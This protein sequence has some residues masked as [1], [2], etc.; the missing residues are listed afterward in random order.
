MDLPRVTDAYIN[1][2]G[3]Y[4][5]F[6]YLWSR[7]RSGRRESH[8][9]SLFDAF[10]AHLDSSHKVLSKRASQTKGNPSKRQQGTLEEE[11]GW[12]P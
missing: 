3:R 2:K 7:G 6:H 8:E 11:P 10:R 4:P 5:F 1:L 9:K 12:S